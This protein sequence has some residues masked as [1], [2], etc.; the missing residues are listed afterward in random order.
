MR[1]AE[2]MWH[3]GVPLVLVALSAN[4]L[5][6]ALFRRGLPELSRRDWG[7]G[8]VVFIL[9]GDAA[10]GD[11][12]P[13]FERQWKGTAAALLALTL[14]IELWRQ[15][16]YRRRTGSRTAEASPARLDAS[17]AG[18]ALEL[19]PAGN[20]VSAETA[21]AAG[22]T[23]VVAMP[24]LGP[25]NDGGTVTRWLKEVGE[26]V[27]AGEPLLEVSTDK[28]DIEFPSPAAGM[29]LEIKVVQNETVLVGATLA[30]I[31]VGRIGS[32]R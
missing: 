28:V 26:T 23:M 3:V 13:L 8:L 10:F 32:E 4:A 20:V 5:L 1:A 14:S 31:G 24:H 30:V 9:A 11:Q 16:S 22:E 2:E 25:G 18:A 27:K 17:A 19:Q 12:R 6:V 7:Y 21:L 15:Y 29:L